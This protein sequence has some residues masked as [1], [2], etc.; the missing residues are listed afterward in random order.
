MTGNIDITVLGK[1][2]E[3]LLTQVRTLRRVQGELGLDVQDVLT[4]TEELK[5]RMDAMEARLGERIDAVAADVS[6]VKLK[7]DQI[8]AKL[9]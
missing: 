6:E 1:N 3:T 2:V 7:L 9:P 5:E 8:L 4:R